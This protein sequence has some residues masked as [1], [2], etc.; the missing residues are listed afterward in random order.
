MPGNQLKGAL[1]RIQCQDTNAV[2]VENGVTGQ[3]AI[4]CSFELGAQ[5][6]T[7]TN[8]SLK[9]SVDGFF[10]VDFNTNCTM[11]VTVVDFNNIVEGSRFWYSRYM[12]D[13]TGG[14]DPPTPALFSCFSEVAEATVQDKGPTRMDQLQIGDMVLTTNQNGGYEYSPVY[15]FGHKAHMVKA[16]FLQLILETTSKPLE[17]SSNHLLYRYDDAEKKPRLVPAS[18]VKTGDRLIT[19]QHGSSDTVTVQG[20]RTITREGI[21]APFTGTGDIVINGIRTSNY[22]A[23]PPEFQKYL[24]FAQ[25]H[26]LQHMAYTPYR[27]Y[28]SWLGCV[29]ETYDKESGVSLAVLSWLP[30]L[31]LLAFLL[32]LQYLAVSAFAIG[33]YWLA[34]KTTTKSA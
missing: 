4:A 32:R 22:I 14:P 5:G 24:T 21:Y 19:F 12:L 34:R 1:L 33:V 2:K 18:S 15:S 6:I 10:T 7:H 28:C 26:W 29:N 20:V 11:D 17:I 3:V 8:A 27:W 25:Q 30:V 13:F 9:D 23:L 31:H 16:S